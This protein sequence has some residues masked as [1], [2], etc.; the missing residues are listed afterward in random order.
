MYHLKHTPKSKK[1]VI[2]TCQRAKELNGKRLAEHPNKEMYKCGQSKQRKVQ[3]RSIETKKKEF[4][5]LLSFFYCCRR[6]YG[7]ELLRCSALSERLVH[8]VVR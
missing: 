1:N 8:C 7:S 3:M 5:A 6:C 2:K 4:K